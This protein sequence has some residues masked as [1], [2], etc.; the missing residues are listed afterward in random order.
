MPR[1]ISPYYPPRAPWY[2]PLLYAGGRVRRSLALDRV[3]PASGVS[4]LGLLGGCVIPGLGVYLR[5]PRIYGLAALGLSATLFVVFLGELGRQLGN[6][7]YG[8]L[9]AVHAT[10]INYLLAPDLAR[11]RFRYRL[12][13]SMG[14]LI[15][16]GTLVYLPAQNFVANNFLTPLRIKDRV[17]IV[18][19]LPPHPTLRRGEWVAYEIRE[20][21]NHNAWVVGGYA[22]G[23]V[24]AVGGDRLRF[25]PSL[26]EVNG[27]P[28]PLRD[29]MPDSGELVIPG[30]G[31]FVWPNVDIS[32]HGY[33]PANTLAQTL[34]AMATIDESQLVGKPF[35]RWF[36]HR[37]F[38]L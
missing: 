23:P 15:V 19:K 2:A 1:P 13:F 16:L 29:N 10:S 8:L 21:G 34:L 18:Q 26:L 35:K 33:V 14:S 38:P 12:L 28:Q 3:R 36:W 30:N 24:L 37:Q 5:G 25:N 7:A 11:L 17:V 22:L 27:Q 9:L 31:W 20:N 4:W 32:G 6:V